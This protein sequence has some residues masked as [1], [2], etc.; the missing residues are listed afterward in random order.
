MDPVR[1]ARRI[2]AIAGIYAAMALASIDGAIGLAFAYAW[3]RTPA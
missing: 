2:F 3:W 1:T